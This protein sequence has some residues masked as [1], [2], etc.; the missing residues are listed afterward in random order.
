MF[1]LRTT[2]WDLVSYFSFLAIASSFGTVVAQVSACLQH[3][4]QA[5]A[6]AGRHPHIPKFEMKIYR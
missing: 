3:H 6:L 1:E 2:S 4:G 5:E